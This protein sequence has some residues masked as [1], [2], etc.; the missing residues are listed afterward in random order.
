VRDEPAALG[1][2][3]TALAGHERELLADRIRKLAD[4]L[5]YDLLDVVD[6]DAVPD[7]ELAVRDL[8]VDAVITPACE[9]LDPARLARVCEVITLIPEA[10]H[11]RD[12]H[13]ENLT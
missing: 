1:A 11:Y 3:S 13:R 10:I 9:H 2:I 8:D 4:R 5:G 6:P 12:G 7:L